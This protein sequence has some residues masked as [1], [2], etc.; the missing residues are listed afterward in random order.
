[1]KI[2]VQSSNILDRL[3]I[4]E[5]FKVIKEAGFDCVDMN[6]D[7]LYPGGDIVNGRPDVRFQGTDEE[8]L[9]MCRPYKEAAEKYGISISQAHAPFPF[10]TK[11][12][13]G[14]AYVMHAVKKCLMICEYLSCPY[15]IVHPCFL[16]YGD[17]LDTEEEWRINMER[18]DELIPYAKKHHVGICLENMFGVH[19]GKVYAAICSNM[20][21]A[22]CYIDE[23]NERAG[24]EIFSFCFDIGHAVLCS[25]E[26]TRAFEALG[27]RVK[28]LHV[29]DNDGRND[30]H[31]FPFMGICDWNRFV[32]GMRSID[33]QDV[34]IS[35][36]TFNGLNAVDAELTKEALT[37]LAATGKL[38]ARR[39]ETKEE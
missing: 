20:E 1:M 28:T 22:V 30:Q 11:N 27:N 38:F 5:G 19:N 10:Y 13:A 7:H 3:G 35:F 17:Q 23:L 12:E 31:L 4:D 33:Y 34:V 15:L 21:E 6:I 2:G 39:I 8:I 32:E 14:N 9:E 18:Y 25:V 24:E 29:H 16:G 37:F 26:L 36:E